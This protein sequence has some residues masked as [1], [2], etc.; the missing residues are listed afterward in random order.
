MSKLT[1][2]QHSV[3]QAKSMI[4]IDREWRVLPRLRVGERPNR[5]DAHDRILDGVARAQGGLGA[6]GID[7][8]LKG[9]MDVHTTNVDMRRGRRGDVELHEHIRLGHDDIRNAFDQLHLMLPS[10]LLTRAKGDHPLHA[11]V[12]QA[13]LYQPH[14]AESVR[15]MGLRQHQSALDADWDVEFTERRLD[16]QQRLGLATRWMLRVAG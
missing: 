15:Q 14:R 9:E 3:G 2:R 1:V 11:E 5:L 13:A 6:V 7:A 16:V 10:V 4:P 12:M 8:R